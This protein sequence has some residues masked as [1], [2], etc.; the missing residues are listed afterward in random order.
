[1]QSPSDYFSMALLSKKKPSLAD[2]EWQRAMAVLEK[3]PSLMTPT[4]LLLALHSRPPMRILQGMLRLN[5]QAASIPKAG[6]TALQIAVRY[7]AD[8]DVICRLLRACP[9][10]LVATTSEDLPAPLVLAQTYRPHE[11][12]LIG[13]LSQ[14]LLYWIEQ[15]KKSRRTTRTPRLVVA[16]PPPCRPP[17]ESSSPPDCVPTV[18][19]VKVIATTLLRAQKRQMQALEQHKRD[20]EE[21]LEA[22]APPTTTRTPMMGG[23]N[24][25][26]A[27]QRRQFMIQLVA[28]NMQERAT[29]TRWKR[30][31]RNM[32]ARLHE[33]ETQVMQRESKMT[34]SL[35]ELETK[36][37]DFGAMVTT[38]QHQ[39]EDQM[40][41]MASKL[42]QESHVNEFFRKDTRLQLDQMMVLEY[43]AAD[44][45]HMLHEPLVYATPFDVDREADDEPMLP[46]AVVAVQERRRKKG[47]LEKV[48]CPV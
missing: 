25:V 11:P 3:N 20:I 42:K 37:M 17:A 19:H 8:H 38:W 24:E 34:E 18:D 45:R 14:P 10:A 13:I 1:M 40:A 27:A 16:K 6:P 9:F 7:H 48:M 30:T 43:S 21:R 47:W 12:D 44:A 23:A 5:P 36:V 39:A 29:K 22:M 4:T 15:S 2:E 41:V 31:E 33:T 28:L 46:R 35:R 26:V 32:M